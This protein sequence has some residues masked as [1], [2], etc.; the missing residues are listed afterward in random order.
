MQRVAPYQPG[1]PGWKEAPTIENK[2]ENNGNQ[3]PEE[4]TPASHTKTNS[5]TSLPHMMDMAMRSVKIT[6][7]K[8]KPL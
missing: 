7:P 2:V 6:P 5:N 3:A 1:N 4:V 8:G